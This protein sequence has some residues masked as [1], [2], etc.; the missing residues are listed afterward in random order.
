MDGFARIVGEHDHTLKELGAHAAALRTIV[1]LELEVGDL[2]L[3]L[4]RQ[5]LPP[6]LPAIDDKITSLEGISE[7]QMSLPAIFLQNAKRHLFFLT[8]H[9]VVGRL[10][11]AAGWAA[12]GIVPN[13]HRGLTVP[14]QAQ[15]RPFL[16]ARG[17]REG[18]PI[19]CCQVGQDGVRFREFFGGLALTTGR[20]R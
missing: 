16:D 9:I 1:H 13:S 3:R 7:G 5:G 15:D 19:L 17:P 20:R 8:A 11:R 10:M 2:G 6:V 14:A 4:R 12:P 18:F